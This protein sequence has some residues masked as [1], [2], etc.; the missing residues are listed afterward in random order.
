MYVAN[1]MEIKNS[2]VNYDA[3]NILMHSMKMWCM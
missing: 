3:D 2:K 1:L